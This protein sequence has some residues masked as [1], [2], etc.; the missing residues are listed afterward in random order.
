M[1]MEVQRRNQNNRR[2][3]EEVLR[4]DGWI[5]YGRGDLKEKGLQMAEVY[6]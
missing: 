6:D 1:E 4:E 5:E 3:R 2:S